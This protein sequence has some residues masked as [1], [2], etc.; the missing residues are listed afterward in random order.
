MTNSSISTASFDLIMF[1]NYY[2][3]LEDFE[4]VVEYD[5]FV[6]LPVGTAS[7]S[8][9]TSLE[10]TSE[11]TSASFYLNGAL[12]G[13]TPITLYNVSANTTYAVSA[14][15]SNYFPYYSTY[16]VQA[17]ENKLFIHLTKTTLLTGST[18]HAARPSIL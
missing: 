1:P 15:Y 8:V 9:V 2:A 5:S 7:L 13:T 6:Y 14:S 11:P 16:D 17:G 3:N 18:I 10:V 4:Q 12:T